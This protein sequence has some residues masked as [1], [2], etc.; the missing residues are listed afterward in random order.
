MGRSKKPNTREQLHVYILASQGDELRY[1]EEMYEKTKTDLVAEALHLWIRRQYD[2]YGEQ[3]R[4]QTIAG[5][6]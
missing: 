1:F 5:V 3:L 4:D 2:L 6:K